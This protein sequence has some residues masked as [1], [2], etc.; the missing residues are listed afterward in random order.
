M[1]SCVHHHQG[2]PSSV[3]PP[4]SSHDHPLMA[5]RAEQEVPGPGSDIPY[6][7]V[8]SA[9]TS[10]LV[11]MLSRIDALEAIPR[12]QVGYTEPIIYY[13]MQPRGTSLFL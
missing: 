9:P 10:A 8:A 7:N 12:L 1:E 11:E 5:G 3:P 13:D 4:H 6:Q 2:S